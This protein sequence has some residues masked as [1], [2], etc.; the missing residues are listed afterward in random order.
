[1]NQFEEWLF[2]AEADF[3]AALWIMKDEDAPYHIVIYHLHQSVEK[4]LKTYLYTQGRDIPLTH[5]LRKLGAI[6]MNIVPEL[7]RFQGHIIELDEYFPK[8]RYPYGDQIN[9]DMA[10]ACIRL[11]TE[12]YEAINILIDLQQGINE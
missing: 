7:K 10:K 6:V 3:K 12:I 5:D 4:I 1:M 11:A 9:E 8:I 2:L